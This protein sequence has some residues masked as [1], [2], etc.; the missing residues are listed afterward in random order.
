MQEGNP[1]SSPFRSDATPSSSL[2]ILS[3]VSIIIMGTIATLRERINYQKSRPVNI[4]LARSASTRDETVRWQTNQF[5]ATCS[6]TWPVFMGRPEAA[7][8]EGF[9]GLFLC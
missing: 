9:F 6:H 3:V 1:I 5:S 8:A 4:I 7:A 2:L